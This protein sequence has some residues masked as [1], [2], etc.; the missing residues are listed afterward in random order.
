MF[1]NVLSGYNHST[2]CD[3]DHCE[4]KDTIVHHKTGGYSCEA[5]EDYNCPWGEYQSRVVI[6]IMGDLRDR[7]KRK[8]AKE[9]C[10]FYNFLEERFWIRNSTFKI[11]E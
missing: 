11:I 3:C 7:V 4:Y 5:D 2:N 10:K 1:I 6:T 9:Y 8:T